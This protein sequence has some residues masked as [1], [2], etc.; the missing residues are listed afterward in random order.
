MKHTVHEV[1]LKNGANGLIIDVAD[2]TVMSY[3]VHFLAGSRFVKDREAYETAHIME[4]M[5][6]G[7]NTKFPDAQAFG[8]DFERNGAHYNAFTS[9]LSMV[10][11][12]NCADFEWDRIMDLQKLA[13]TKPLFIADELKSE[14]GNVRNELTGYLNSHPRL[15][16]PK[17]QAALGEPVMGYEDRLKILH[18][19][20]LEDIKEHYK[21]THSLKNMRFAIAGN[22][23]EAKLNTIMEK[24]EEWELPEG[25]RLDIPHDKL[26]KAKP[27]LIRRREAANLTFAW[28]IALN[29]KLTNEELDAMAAVDH[30]LTGTLHSRILG[31]AR[32]AGLAYGMYSDATAYHFN[33]TWDFSAQVNLETVEPLFD[34]IV[35]QVGEVLSGRITD[36]E[37]EN[38]KQYALGKHQMGAQT[39]G[40]INSWYG[41][42]YFF[43]EH[44]DDFDQRPIAIKSITKEAMVEVAREFIK[45]GKWGLGGVGSNKLDLMN[46]LNDKVAA[47]F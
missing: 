47:L 5:A 2:A 33:S 1:N 46:R 36:E 22:I 35:K 23:D 4:H 21:R 29:R 31:S 10:Y 44:V 40:Q 28:S 24:I 37:V 32:K 16:W 42:R 45:P 27:F 18:N 26:H 41:S 39:V 13:I 15:L 30:L 8:A 43:D 11:I 9:D 17:M 14:S 7:A 25:K 19:T 6:F 38:A 20:T 12:A 3:Q 34:I